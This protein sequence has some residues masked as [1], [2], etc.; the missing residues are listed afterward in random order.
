[1][2]SEFVW[3][4][5]PADIERTHLARFM[6]L[7]GLADL[8][9]LQVRSTTDVGWFTNAIIEYLD[10]RFQRPYREVLD[11]SAGVQFPQWWLARSA[12]MPPRGQMRHLTR[13]SRPCAGTLPKLMWRACTASC[14]RAAQYCA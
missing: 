2:T 1:M 13:A 3:F 12:W 8:A 11:I 4:P 7:H 14:W 6:Q 10:I 5:A 9:E